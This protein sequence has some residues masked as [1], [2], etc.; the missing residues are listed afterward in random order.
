MIWQLMQHDLAWKRMRWFTLAVAAFCALWHFFAPVDRFVALI[1]PLQVWLASMTAGLLTSL[2]QGVDTRFQS[3]LPVTVR[4]V[5]L[6]R[7]FSSA[8]LMWLPFAAGTVVLLA[9]R[10]PATEW[11]TTWPLGFCVAF[12][13][14]ALA[15]QCVIIRRCRIPGWLIVVVLPVWAIVFGL[16]GAMREIREILAFIVAATVLKTWLSLPK[17]FQANFGP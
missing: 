11:L 6:A 9:L 5:F 4:Q 1:L 12:T 7:M 16:A 15:I 2:A 3:T 13:C 17:S 14:T 8:A 10:D